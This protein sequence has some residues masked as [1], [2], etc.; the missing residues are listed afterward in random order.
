[1][2][3][4]ASGFRYGKAQ[5][6]NRRANAIHPFNRFF[7]PERAFYSERAGR[8]ALLVSLITKNR[9]KGLSHCDERE[10]ASL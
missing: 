2:S 7:V 10:C 1:M 8:N 9:H 5:R 6:C 4:R 3:P